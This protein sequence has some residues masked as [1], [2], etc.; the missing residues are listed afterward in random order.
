METHKLVPNYKSSTL[1][2]IAVLDGEFDFADILAEKIRNQ[3]VTV[4]VD[5]TSKSVGDR[6]KKASADAIPYFAALGSSEVGELKI[7]IKKL[8]DRTETSFALDENGI[9]ELSQMIIQNHIT[10]LQ[11]KPQ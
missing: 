3:G 8:D 7:K 5:Y 10:Q 2:Y 6:I 9:T 4:A 1:L 11:E